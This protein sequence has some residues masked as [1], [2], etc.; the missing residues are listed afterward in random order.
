MMLTY[1]YYY[2]LLAVLAAAIT[3]G[4]VK[5]CLNSGLRH[6]FADRPD[7]RKL[8]QSLI[9]RMGGLC[10]ILSIMIVITVEQ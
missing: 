5:F 2:A 1:L 8:H 4:A 6:H 3:A 9:P 7:S 10:I